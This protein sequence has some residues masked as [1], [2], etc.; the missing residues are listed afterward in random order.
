MCK[1]K[2]VNPDHLELGTH[3]QNIQDK[4]RDGTMDCGEKHYK[5]KLTDEVVLT[6]RIL[7][8]FYK[9]IEVSAMLGI[10][11]SHIQHIVSRKA[12]SHV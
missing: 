4:H 2:C 8:L 12:W 11:K 6:I 10:E 9:Q 1:N 7:A 3:T 5:S